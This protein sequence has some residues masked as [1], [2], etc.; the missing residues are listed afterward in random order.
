MHE[1]CGHRLPQR[2]WVSRGQEILHLEKEDIVLEFLVRYLSEKNRSVKFHLVN[3]LG[4]RATPALR[5]P[6]SSAVAHS[7]AEVAVGH[8]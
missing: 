5:Q 6:L 8:A 7:R 3:N 4:S 1:G 2:C